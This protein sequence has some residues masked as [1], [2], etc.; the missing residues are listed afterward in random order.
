[1]LGIVHW[2]HAPR[3]ENK[4]KKKARDVSVT[5]RNLHRYGSLIEVS[6]CHAWS[7]SIS[8][9]C[10]AVIIETQSTNQTNRKKKKKKNPNKQQP[11]RPSTTRR[12]QSGTACEVRLGPDYLLTHLRPFP[13]CAL[14]PEV[15]IVFARPFLCCSHTHVTINNLNRFKSTA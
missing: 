2:K 6:L 14:C 4:T 11:E 5:K 8:Y 7:Y 9:L 13:L 1:M 12:V 15:V 3:S 10:Q